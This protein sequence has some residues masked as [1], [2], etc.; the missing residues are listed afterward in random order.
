[1]YIC[2]TSYATSIVEAAAPEKKKSFENDL[3]DAAQKYEWSPYYDDNDDGNDDL[4]NDHDNDGDDACN[5][6]LWPLWAE[7]LCWQKLLWDP[8]KFDFFL[9]RDLEYKT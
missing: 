5:F 4:D 8:A 6:N 9:S 1:M 3:D 7:G 2:F